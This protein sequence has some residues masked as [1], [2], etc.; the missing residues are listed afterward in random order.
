MLT[1]YKNNLAHLF[2]NEAMILCTILGM[3]TLGDIKQGFQIDQVWSNIP[4]LSNLLSE[5]FIYMNR[6]KTKEDFIQILKHM[7]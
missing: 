4:F 6:M 7:Q 2:I 3:N 5:E 1:Y